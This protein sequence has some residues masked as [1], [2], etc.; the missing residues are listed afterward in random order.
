M[1]KEILLNNLLDHFL[2]GKRLDNKINI[3]LT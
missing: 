1:H 3:P 2:I